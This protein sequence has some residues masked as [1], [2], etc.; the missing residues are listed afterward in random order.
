MTAT[1]HRQKIFAAIR[2]AKGSI[3]ANEVSKIDAFITSLGIPMDSGF[4]AALDIILHHEGGYVHHKS[5][6]GGRTNLGVTQ[7]TW[8]GWVGRPSNEAEMRALTVDKVAPLY[9]KN[10]W[11]AVKGDDLPP[12]LALCVFDFGVNAGP[13]RAIK[14]LQRLVGAAADGVIG[15]NTLAAVKSAGDVDALV[16]GYQ[17]FRRAYYKSLSTFP[18]FGK[19][20]M[21]RVDEVEAAALALVR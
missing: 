4:N 16:R 10:Y 18:T 19:G 20:W 12:A 14:M 13:S 5:D 21:R 15:P 17:N 8:E 9:R 1:S 11:D 3:P 2:A 6:P 7:R